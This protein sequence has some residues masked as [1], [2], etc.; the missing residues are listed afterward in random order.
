LDKTK[1][2]DEIVINILAVKLGVSVSISCFAILY[3]DLTRSITSILARSISTKVL[4]AQVAENYRR[5]MQIGARGLARSAGTNIRKQKRI[6]RALIKKKLIDPRI[7]IL[8]RAEA[9]L[10]KPETYVLCLVLCKNIKDLIMKR[11]L[12]I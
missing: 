3:L 1:E 2:L 4:W 6:T 12:R 11:I 10:N 8:I 5:N 7:I 9:R